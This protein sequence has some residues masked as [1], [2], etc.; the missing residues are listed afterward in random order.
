MGNVPV[1]CKACQG[2]GKVVCR[3]CFVGDGYDIGPMRRMMS[4][5]N[6]SFL[7]Y[8]RLNIL[9]P[10]EDTEETLIVASEASD[11]EGPRTE[12]TQDSCNGQRTA[13]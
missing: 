9:E 3:E 1:T 4:V 13:K 5:E 12:W 10:T 7:D 2:F 8:K 6:P 11:W